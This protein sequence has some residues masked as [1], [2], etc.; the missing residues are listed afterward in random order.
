MVL[1]KD[2]SKFRSPTKVSGTE[3]WLNSYGNADNLRGRTKALL[4]YCGVDPDTVLFKPK[5]P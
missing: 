4:K 3:L 1:D 5:E 2:D